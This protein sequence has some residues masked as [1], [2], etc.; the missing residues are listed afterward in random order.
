VDHYTRAARWEIEEH[1]RVVTDFER[2][3]LLERG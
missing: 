1:D 3:R 2:Q